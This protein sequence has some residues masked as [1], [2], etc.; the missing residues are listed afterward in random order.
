MSWATIP[1]ARFKAGDCIRIPAPGDHRDFTNG[2]K[3]HYI[4]KKKEFYTYVLELQQTDLQ[5]KVISSS[6]TSMSITE[7]DKKAKAFE[8]LN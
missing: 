8:C 5:D 7:V 4:I 2:R 6:T 1:E 3:Y